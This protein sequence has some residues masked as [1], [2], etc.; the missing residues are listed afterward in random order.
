MS[1]L[2]TMTVSLV[3]DRGRSL[4]IRGPSDAVRL[5]SRATALGL[6]SSSVTPCRTGDGGHTRT[7]TV[8]PFSASAITLSAA[9]ITTAIRGLSSI[10]CH[11][12]GT[13]MAASGRLWLIILTVAC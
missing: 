11:M 13:A 6:S 1:R 8:A 3:S 10:F 7:R 12:N 5:V 9:S 2:R 4:E